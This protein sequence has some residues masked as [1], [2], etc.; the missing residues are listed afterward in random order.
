M[1]IIR[2]YLYAISLVGVNVVDEKEVLLQT[3]YARAD[4]TGY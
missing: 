1:E 4:S 3:V 2:S